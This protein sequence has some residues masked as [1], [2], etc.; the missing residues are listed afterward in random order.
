MQTSET[1]DMRCCTNIKIR[2]LWRYRRIAGHEL[3]KLSS[4]K[5]DILAILAASPQE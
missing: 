3:P 4:G 1:A 2:C 5:P